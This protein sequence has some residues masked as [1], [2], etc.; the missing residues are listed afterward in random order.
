[1]TDA[2]DNRHR[3]I[4]LTPRMHAV[5]VDVLDFACEEHPGDVDA[6][7][8]RNIVKAAKRVEPSA[9][10]D[11]DKVQPS[12]VA[13]EQRPLETSHASVDSGGRITLHPA[14][15]TGS[16]GFAALLRELRELE[17]PEDACA[18]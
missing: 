2:T 1:M 11:C 13:A 4:M 14:T 9:E 8:L 3:R 18:R 5:L 16:P 12:G 15:S 10:S 17:D 6:R 7:R